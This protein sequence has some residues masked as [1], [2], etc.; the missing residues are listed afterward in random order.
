[1]SKT[2]DINDQTLCSIH[3]KCFHR[4]T[5]DR[6]MC[7]LFFQPETIFDDLK[8]AI[9]QWLQHD[10]LETLHRAM[11]I[12]PFGPREPPTDIDRFGLAN[13]SLCKTPLV[14]TVMAKGIFV[15]FMEVLDE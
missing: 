7:L 1:M 11:P 4:E 15:A 14:Y 3:P 6:S 2:E 8:D 9:G 12:V 10:K 5:C 13:R